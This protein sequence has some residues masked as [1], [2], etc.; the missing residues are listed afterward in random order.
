MNH[1]GRARRYRTM[2]LRHSRD[3]TDIAEST[4]VLSGGF[5][6]FFLLSSTRI[7]A[8]NICPTPTSS[9]SSSKIYLSKQ[10]RPHWGFVHG[11]YDD[12]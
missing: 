1:L 9:I 4:L 12:I 7:L 8:H 2:S 11:S 6:F 3:R 10:L 5:F